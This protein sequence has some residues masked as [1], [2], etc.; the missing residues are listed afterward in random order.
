MIELITFLSLEEIMTKKN[1]GGN[2]YG[3][4]QIFIMNSMHP[5]RR[6]ERLGDQGIIFSITMIKE[7]QPITENS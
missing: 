4:M 1:L 2:K 5:N 6:K 7:I 3:V